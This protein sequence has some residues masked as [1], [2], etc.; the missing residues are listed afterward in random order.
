[1]LL[2]SSLTSLIVHLMQ[3]LLDFEQD[4]TDAVTDPWQDHLRS[5]VHGAGTLQTHAL[6]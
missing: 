2:T 3:T 6:K 1:M 5:D 4:I